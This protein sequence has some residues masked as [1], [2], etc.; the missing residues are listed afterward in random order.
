MKKKLAGKI[1]AGII[2]A[3]I[4]LTGSLPVNV[5]AAWQ[6]YTSLPLGNYKYGDLYF[7]EYGTDYDWVHNRGVDY[8]QFTR[9][10]VID[11]LM[12]FDGIED[13]TGQ[14]L[15]YSVSDKSILSINKNGVFTGKKV[16]EAKVTV[17]RKGKK[18]GVIDVT[19]EPSALLKND[20]T[21]TLGLNEEVALVK[22]A[23][24]GAKYTVTAKG[25]NIRF[26]KG[27]DKKYRDVPGVYDM[28]VKK[29][30]NY[31]VSVTELYKGKKKNLGTTTLKVAAAKPLKKAY[32]GK[33]GGYAD[34]NDLFNYFNYDYYKPE[35]VS[36]KDIVQIEKDTKSR[37]YT[38]ALL[39]FG[40]AKISLV[41][42][43]GKSYATATVD[44][45]YNNH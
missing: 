14:G 8:S 5:Q 42:S 45:E 28:T 20:N 38:I 41:D 34:I 11:Y 6:D 13:K 27:K 3:S 32:S 19:V 25:S 37:T 39:K 31:K 15:T 10:D 24:K 44:V 23:N 17:K 21:F 43:K 12:M 4:A 30:G 35:I 33:E 7:G 22:N 9:N 1:A 16:G 29:P 36:G 18:I 2:S 26:T 40:S